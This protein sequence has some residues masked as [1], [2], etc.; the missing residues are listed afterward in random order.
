MKIKIAWKKP[1]A[2]KVLPA[3]KGPATYGEKCFKLVHE[4][5]EAELMTVGYGV[6]IFARRYDERYVPLYIGIG[7]NVYKRTVKQ[8]FYRRYGND[9]RKWILGDKNDPSCYLL[10]GKLEE[11][12]QTPKK[13]LRHLEKLLIANA[14]ADRR[15]RSEL[16]N[17]QGNY[18][19]SWTGNRKTKHG[20]KN[21]LT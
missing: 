21:L 1:I 11:S 3:K 17:T 19:I 18:S 9:L 10:V 15:R 20:L 8:H 7:K 2:L 16:Y 12:L 14:A 6:Y 4:E 13:T 5:D